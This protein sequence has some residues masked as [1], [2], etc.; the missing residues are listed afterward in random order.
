MRLWLK[1][2]REQK[3]LT[4]KQVAEAVGISQQYYQF[5]EQGKRIEPDK[6]ENE[7]AIATYLGFD[8]TKFFETEVQEAN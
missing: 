1:E 6:V 4:Q 5:I 8:W 7:K 3:N 2:I